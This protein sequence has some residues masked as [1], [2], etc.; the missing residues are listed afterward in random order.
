LGLGLGLGLSCCCSWCSSGCAFCV[1]PACCKAS[2]PP[3]SCLA[4][5]SLTSVITSWACDGLR[6]H[7]LTSTS[8]VRSAMPEAHRR[9]AL[10]RSSHFVYLSSSYSFILRHCA[11]VRPVAQDRES[12][13]PTC[14]VLHFG[15]DLPTPLSPQS[16]AKP[17][18]MRCE[19]RRPGKHPDG[20]IK[21]RGALPNNMQDPTHRAAIYSGTREF[22]KHR[23]RNKTYISNEQLQAMGL[24]IDRG[25]NNF[26]TSSMT[27]ENIRRGMCHMIPNRARESR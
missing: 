24:G 16:Y 21:D 5:L 17:E 26:Q 3:P 22:I 1:V 4:V 13:A 2:S 19:N 23:S 15:A 14:K 12:S 18:F 10:W 11:S 6:V 27:S 20:K 8:V 25:I 7:A 9:L